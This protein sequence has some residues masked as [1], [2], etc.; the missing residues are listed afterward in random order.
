MKPIKHAVSIVVRD[1]NKTL[2]VLRSPNKKRFPSTWSLP[3]YFV[4]ENETHRETIERIGKDKLGVELEP[5]GLL[6][7]GYGERDEF[8]L[9]M[10]DYEARIVGGT[11]CVNSEDYTDMRWEEP[12][13]FLSAM[14]TKGE[15]TRLYEECL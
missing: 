6:N 2:F 15:C 12:R 11:L 4:D 3:S 13:S 8:R 1:K 14:R 5:L 10:H 7:E 9:F